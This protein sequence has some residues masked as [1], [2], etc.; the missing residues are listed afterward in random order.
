MKNL[1]LEEVQMVLSSHLSN[2][3]GNTYLKRASVSEFTNIYFFK[4]L[5]L[6]FFFNRQ[7]GSLN[8]CLS[9]LLEK[10]HQIIVDFDFF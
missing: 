2:A 8:I 3:F 10:P 4:W 1:K 6:S 5:A 9:I 7:F